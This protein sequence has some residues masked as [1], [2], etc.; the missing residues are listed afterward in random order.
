MRIVAL[1]LFILLS[2]ERLQAQTLAG[3]TTD[4]EGKPLAGASIVL[5]KIKDSSLVKLSI[6]NID[7]VYEFPS[8]PAGVYFV[9]VSHIGYASTNSASFSL[10]G[11]G[12]VHIPA[13]ML[14][15]VSREL[16]KADVA[17]ARPMVEVRPDKI[18][19]NVEGNINAVGED[20][21]ELLRKS[22]GITVDNSN[23]LSLNGKIGVQVYVDGRPTYLS[24][25]D[26]AQ[27]LKTVQSTSVEA[28]EIISN[29]SAKYE[30]AGSGGIINIRLKKDKSFG[31]NLTAGAG[32]NIGTYSKYTATA[33]FN[34]REKNFNIFA[35]YT[36]HNA[37]ELYHSVYYRTQL[38]TLFRQSDVLVTK[39]IIHT[40]RTGLDYTIDK[41]STLGVLVSGTFVTDSL[42][43]NSET[44]IIYVPTNITNRLL[45]ADNRTKEQ[46][47]NGNF[48]LN[49]RYA[50]G[51]GHELTLNADYGLYRIRSN[52]LQPNHYF[53]STGQTLL[54]S[55]DYNILSPTNIDIYSFKADYDQ[56]FLKGRLGFGI[57][58]SYVTSANNFQEYD[59]L[60]QQHVLDSLSSDDFNYKEN[61]NAAYATYDRT[62]KNWV[63]RGGLRVE[64]T[65]S[66]GNSAGW[67]Q[68]VSDFSPYD[69]AYPRHYTDFFPSASVTWNQKPKQQWTLT[70]GR[71]LDR[72]DYQDLNPFV[73]KLDDYSFSKGNT[74]LRPQYAN[75]LGL[76]YSYDYKLTVGL[77]YSHVSGLFANLPDTT[78]RSKTVVTKVNLAS[79]D[80]IGLNISY[81]LQ[82]KWYSFFAS[83]NG[84]YALYQANFGV[85][86][87][88]DLNVFNT[89]IYS[90]HSF[91]LGGGWAASVSEYYSSPSILEATLQS[92]SLWGVDAGLQKTLFSGN[93]TIKAS[94]SDI[95]NKM[96]FSATSNFAGQYIY[97]AGTYESRQ[98][99]LYFTYR[100]GNKQVRAVGRHE[101]GAEDENKRVSQGI[102]GAT[103]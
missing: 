32:Y 9:T 96:G 68:V 82:Y 77:N 48:N 99:K 10:T 83:A 100:L 70:Y 36:Y 22:P 53:D 87:T 28:I 78:D 91:R 18:V 45:V 71:R 26:L 56:N 89:T 101:S 63:I 15:R 75:N 25:N 6:S 55:D 23:N 80:I 103:P 49:Y 52:Q 11:D 81:S 74:Q 41:K 98:L 102:G 4:N 61:I 64:N 29:P 72:P 88:I 67:Q 73:F 54:Y 31:T 65:N 35:D 44:P 8:L 17:A 60:N 50:D 76:T 3:S 7:G 14:T 13:I 30:A 97:T 51:A 16:Q 27:Y 20:A 43:S 93:A 34:H 12:A 39:T 59:L 58:V 40:F 85:G 62:F 46:R 79:Q 95:F 69:S 42:I 57:K 5:K 1:F 86:R 94:V 38:D 84:H 21:L 19:L 47:N 33:S 90:Q 37:T 24:G 92:R 2:Y 66:K